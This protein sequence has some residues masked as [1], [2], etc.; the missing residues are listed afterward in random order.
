MPFG[1]VLLYNGAVDF[2]V[3]LWVHF[4]NS[5]LRSPY[6]EFLLKKSKMQ[7]LYASEVRGKTDNGSHV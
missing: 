5:F 1:V 7:K 6:V 2:D 4:S 3:V